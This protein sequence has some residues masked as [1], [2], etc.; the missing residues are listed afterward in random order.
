MPPSNQSHSCGTLWSPP[1]TLVPSSQD[2]VNQGFPF[3]EFSGSRFPFNYLANQ[4]FPIFFLLLGLHTYSN[5]FCFSHF[6]IKNCF[7]YWC[8][9]LNNFSTNM[10]LGSD[11]E[12]VCSPFQV[13]L[14]S[15]LLNQHPLTDSAFI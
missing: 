6:T 13:T 5:F 1:P 4:G 8:F 3:S 15:L 7:P 10:F 11:L 9:F 2:W 12:M 14:D